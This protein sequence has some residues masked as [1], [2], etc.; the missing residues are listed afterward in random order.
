MNITPE[1][2]EDQYQRA[3]AAWPWLP[4][5]ERS[6][7]LPRMLLFAVGSRE[8]NLTNEIGDGGHGHGVWQYDDR[9]HPIPAGFDHNVQQQ[10][11]TAGQELS[12]LLSTYGDV[13][14]AANAYNSGSPDD[15]ATTGHDYG[16]DVL[17]RMQYLA[18]RHQED[19]MPQPADVTSVLLTPA[20]RGAWLLQAD[21]GIRTLGDARFCGSYPGLPDKDRQQAPGAPPRV[22]LAITPNRAGRAPGYTIWDTNGEAYDFPTPEE[23][24]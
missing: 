16:L 18:N 11:G 9:W 7:A 1:E 3:K 15:Q 12:E 24:T 21:G 20:G 4:Q 13:R 10:A 19:D 22:F 8:T 17:E 6:H 5:L 14:R 2:L 23:P